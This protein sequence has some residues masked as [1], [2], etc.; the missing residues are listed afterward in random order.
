VLLKLIK[1]L[2]IVL[3]PDADAPA[4]ASEGQSAVSLEDVC[5]VVNLL[6]K[7]GK[8][9]KD[10]LLKTLTPAYCSAVLKKT[11]DAMP[12][13]PTLNF[14]KLKKKRVGMTVRSLNGPLHVSQRTSY[15]V[16]TISR[17][18]LYSIGLGL[19]VLEG[20]LWG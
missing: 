9:K 3:G 17:A 14:F 6:K 10:S 20:T 5:D 4:E 1:V 18:A 13:R 8:G 7:S 11:G 16:Q 12:P 2:V 15:Y 19:C